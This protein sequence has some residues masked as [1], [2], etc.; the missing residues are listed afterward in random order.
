M[1]L[2]VRMLTLDTAVVPKKIRPLGKVDA[3]VKASWQRKRAY[4]KV[5][6][7]CSVCVPADAMPLL[8]G[9]DVGMELLLFCG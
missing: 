1:Y 2:M 5:S 9:W 6:L 7:S 4:S 8:R 3:K